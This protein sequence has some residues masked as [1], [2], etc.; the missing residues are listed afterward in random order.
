VETALQ[1]VGANLKLNFHID[2]Q[3]LTWLICYLQP[4]HDS[5]LPLL[6]YDKG[7][8][9][10]LCI[11]YLAGLYCNV[12]YT[13]SQG[14]KVKIGSS[15]AL[16]QFSIM[17]SNSKNV[18]GETEWV[19]FCEKR[20][21][22]PFPI[23][24]ESID[25][26]S[27]LIEQLMDTFRNNAYDRSMTLVIARSDEPSIDKE[28]VDGRHRIVALY[29]LFKKGIQA[30]LP[31]ITQED[32]PDVATLNCRIAHYVQMSRSKHPA[33]AKKIVE[34]RIRDV[35]ES[36]IERYG[37]KLPDK[38]VKMGF[39][40]VTIVNK[41]LDEVK[42]KRQQ[43]RK[44]G[45]R[46]LKATHPALQYDFGGS[47]FWGT[48]KRYPNEPIQAGPGDK[49]DELTSFRPCPCCKPPKRLAIVT[50]LDGSLKDVKLPAEEQA[51]NE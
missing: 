39:S 44:P 18:K 28:V 35:I 37:D 24:E 30:K 17:V 11:R 41:L 15:L 13:C 25:L 31:P 45:Q 20:G 6:L 47:E 33:L 48:S 8:H 43:K 49:L 22:K 32:I 2:G 3:V 10:R 16:T 46:P 27:G 36:N 38:I 14:Q 40:S 1:E 34:H 9:Q 5:Y 29:R 26:D 23:N 19:N 12:Y 42:E 7:Q 50:G 21:L 4:D 51:V